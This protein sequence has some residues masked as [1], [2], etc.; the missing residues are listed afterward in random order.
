MPE[1]KNNET[2]PTNLS[3]SLLIRKIGKTTYRVTLH[4]SQNSTETMADKVN[5]LM[6]CDAGSSA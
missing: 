3:T 2:P 6:K 4:F 5:R 1:A